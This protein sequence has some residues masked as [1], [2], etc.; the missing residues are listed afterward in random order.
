[1][2]LIIQSLIF[3]SFFFE[4]GFGIFMPIFAVFLTNEIPGGNVVVVGYAAGIYWIL[5]SLLQV[6]VGRFLDRKK[7]EFD[8]F[9]ALFAGHFIMGLVVFLYIFANS[10]LHIYLLQ[11]LLAVG[12]ALAVP[13]WFAMFLRH[14]DRSK[15]GFEW[16][17]HSSI[18][19]G[20]GTGGAGAL[21]GILVKLYG[22][23]FIFI[24]GAIL[25]WAS[26][27]ILLMLRRH[28]KDGERPPALKPPYPL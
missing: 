6:P 23:Q 19:Y 20:L 11:A 15:E 28:L 1:M 16:S 12:G 2:N 25:V 26:L 7:G 22:F 9:W 4:V 3:A 18:S 8:D 5:K 17:I 10:P 27:P 14:V 13:S 24:A 21:G